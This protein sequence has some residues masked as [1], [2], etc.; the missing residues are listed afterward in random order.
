MELDFE[1]DSLCVFSV[2]E[3][4]VFLKSVGM[5]LFTLIVKSLFH[6]FDLP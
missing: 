1:T 6:L 5:I 3:D 4:S 2:T